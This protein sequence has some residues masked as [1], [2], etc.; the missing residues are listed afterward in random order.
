MDYSHSIS[1]LSLKY[2]P[3]LLDLFFFLNFT[4][5]YWYFVNVKSAQ[6]LNLQA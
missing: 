3:S 4:F 2:F 6:S 5:D 1:I